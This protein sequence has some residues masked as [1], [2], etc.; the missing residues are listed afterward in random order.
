MKDIF[1]VEDSKFDRA[2]IKGILTSLEYSA[3]YFSEA[4]KVLEQLENINKNKLPQL[5]IVDIVLAGKLSGY[6][7]AEKLK[8][9]CDIPIIFLT[10]DS[11]K[12]MLNQQLL[13]GDLFLN[14]PIDYHE[15]KNNIGSFTNV[16]KSK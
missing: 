14:K 11:K 9:K 1:V 12:K 4:E 6:Q 7:L 16:V 5:M 3:E 2:K 10:A 15:L 13:N 8:R